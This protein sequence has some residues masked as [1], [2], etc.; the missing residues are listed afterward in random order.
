MSNFKNVKN[1]LFRKLW[2][3]LFTCVKYVHLSSVHLSVIY[4]YSFLIK[5]KKNYTKHNVS[6]LMTIFSSQNYHLFT[7][8]KSVHLSDLTHLYIY[9][10]HLREKK[11][12]FKTNFFF[13]ICH[14]SDFKSSL[15]SY[16]LLVTKK[17]WIKKQ[18]I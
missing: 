11:T 5:F 18:I 4:I 13:C 1:F 9:I 12:I 15:K 14:R 8:V 3:H 6:R 17:R 7:C 10:V 2:N 16:S